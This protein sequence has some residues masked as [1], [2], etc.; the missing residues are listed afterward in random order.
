MVTRPPPRRQHS[1]PL[2][3][4]AELGKRC[5][6]AVLTWGTGDQFTNTTYPQ[7]YTTAVNPNMDPN[8]SLSVLGNNGEFPTHYNM[9]SASASPPIPTPISGNPSHSLPA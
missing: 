8:L 2:T 1:P 3:T 4:P 5:G 7:A 6:Q 9:P